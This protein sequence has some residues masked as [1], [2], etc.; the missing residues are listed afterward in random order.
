M[1]VCGELACCVLVNLLWVWVWSIVLVLL[2][3]YCIVIICD[4]V[5]VGFGFVGLYIALRLADDLRLT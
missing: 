4:T 3:C 2:L 5:V 1:S